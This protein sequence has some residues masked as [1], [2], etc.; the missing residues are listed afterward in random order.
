ML[1]CVNYTAVTDA[2]VACSKYEPVA[3]GGPQVVFGALSGE[4]SSKH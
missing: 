2:G 4:G 3:S 1:R